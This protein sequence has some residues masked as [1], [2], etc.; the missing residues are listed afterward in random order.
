MRK[1][2]YLIFAIIMFGGV[3]F[4]NLHRNQESHVQSTWVWDTSE[5]QS[6]QQ[7]NKPI[8]RGTLDNVCR[9]RR[10]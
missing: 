8:F 9:E 7:T 6:N 4:L 10:V 1:I 2:G 3:A 5:F